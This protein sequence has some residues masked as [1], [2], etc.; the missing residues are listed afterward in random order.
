MEEDN[1]GDDEK[2][3]ENARVCTAPRLGAE[4]CSAAVVVGKTL[5]QIGNLAQNFTAGKVL[6]STFKPNPEEERGETYETSR[7]RKQIRTE[8]HEVLK[9]FRK[10]DA[11]SKEEEF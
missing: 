3:D 5:Q 10:W 1:D 4:M 9:S 2:S 7:L 6:E 11:R 8:L